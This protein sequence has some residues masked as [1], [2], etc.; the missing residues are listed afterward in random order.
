MHFPLGVIGRRLV[1][2]LPPSASLWPWGTWSSS[3]ALAMAENEILTR[4]QQH[5]DLCADTHAAHA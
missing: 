5:M 4:I 2:H 3:G 1:P